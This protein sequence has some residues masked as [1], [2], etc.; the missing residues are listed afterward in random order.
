MNEHIKYSANFK[1]KISEY[2]PISEESFNLLENIMSFKKLKKDQVLLNFGQVSK[3]I[4]FV[5]KGTIIAYF[6]D[7]KGNTYNKNIF[8]EKQFAGSTVSALLKTPSEF[9]LQAIE[10]TILITINYQH[11]KNLIY[12]N[13]EL[14]CFY[15][16][17]LE[18]NWIIDKEQREV[19]LVMENAT[20]RYLKFLTDYPD[21]DKRISLNHIASHLGIT[22]TQL[23]RIRKKLKEK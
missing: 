3:N 5:C 6:T 23:S 18:K 1:E 22:P 8:L 17:Y 7:D 14:N 20:T 12:S 21:I 16:A 13:K 19:S 10:E 2:F 4:Y 15:I 11:Y 9:T